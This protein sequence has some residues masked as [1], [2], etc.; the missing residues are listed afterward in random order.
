MRCFSIGP[1]KSEKKAAQKSKLKN[2]AKLGEKKE[3]V[4]ST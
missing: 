4:K 3:K 1:V 2:C